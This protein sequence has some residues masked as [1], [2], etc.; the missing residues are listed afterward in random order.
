MCGIPRKNDNEFLSLAKEVMLLRCQEDK[1]SE[2]QVFIFYE[3][4]SHTQWLSISSVVQGEGGNVSWRIWNDVY[5]FFMA[6]LSHLIPYQTS[7]HYP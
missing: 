6:M 5:G 3:V 4:A 2:I 1:V 7:P